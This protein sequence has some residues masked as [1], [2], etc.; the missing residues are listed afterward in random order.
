MIATRSPSS[1]LTTT[2]AQHQGAGQGESPNYLRMPMRELRVE[3]DRL[4]EALERAHPASG[5]H[6]EYMLV[7]DILSTRSDL[8]RRRIR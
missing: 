7:R 6:Y 1:T 2:P 4:Y 3:V 5:V 8:A